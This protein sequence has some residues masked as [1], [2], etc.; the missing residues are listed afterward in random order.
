MLVEIEVF[1]PENVDFQEIVHFMLEVQQQL[2]EQL[3][4]GNTK[5]EIERFVKRAA[6]NHFYYVLARDGKKLVG[7]VGLY[8]LSESMIYL[9]P[10]NPLVLPRKDSDDIFVQLVK[11]SIEHTQSLG[12]NRLE[13]FLMELTDD[14]RGTYDRVRPLYEAGGMRRGNEWTQMW[15]DLTTLTL[16]EP[17]FPEGFILKRI[18]EV[19]NEEIWPTYNE[20]FL[21]SGDNRY[22]NQTEAQRRENFDNFF[23]RS[24]S[25]EEDASLLLYDK[26]QVVGFMKINIYDIGGFVNG[27]GIHPDYRKRG[28]AKKLMTASLVRAA[29][30]RME[31]VV[32]EVDI[33]NSQAIALYEKLGFKRKRGSISHIWTS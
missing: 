33:E 26:D 10:W 29:E 15:C 24:I 20:T 1:K 31:N 2:D 17:D 13:V 28:L 30:N 7:L 6:Q 16:K 3:R 19:D 9:D 23:D 8:V 4:S 21:S 22:L 12:R 11:A 25:I 5:E 32:L 18:I 14:I 27:I